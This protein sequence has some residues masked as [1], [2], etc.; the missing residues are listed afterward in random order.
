MT[1]TTASLSTQQVE[2]EAESILAQTLD[3]LQQIRANMQREQVEIDRLKAESQIITAHTD[4]LL[5][6]LRT[7]LDKLTAAG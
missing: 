1:D 5:S 3:E 7:Q 2:A 4:L 6:R